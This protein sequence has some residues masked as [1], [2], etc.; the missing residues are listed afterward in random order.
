M[1]FERLKKV[2]G[3][4]V[5]FCKRNSMIEKGWN[6]EEGSKYW[7]MWDCVCAGCGMMHGLMHGWAQTQ[8]WSQRERF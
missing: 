4:V 5:W 6:R 2:G 3:W 7:V 8:F 1:G